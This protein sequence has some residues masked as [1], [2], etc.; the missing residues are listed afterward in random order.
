METAGVPVAAPAR[1]DR[2]G[3]WPDLDLPNVLWFFGAVIAAAASVAIIDKIPESHR[4][5]WEL[6]GSLGFLAAYAL[7]ARLLIRNGWRIPGGLMAADAAVMVPAAG[8]GFTRL[9]DVYPKDS[10]FDPFQ[11]FSGAV[12]GIGCATIVAGLLAYAL[13]R[14][15]ASLFVVVLAV[16]LTAQLLATS[17]DASGDGRSVT[18]IVVGGALVLIGLGLDAVGRR[19]EAFWL[20]L[21]GFA[22]IAGAL[23]YFSLVSEDGERHGWLPMLI[24]GSCVLLLAGPLRRRVWATFGAAGIGGAFIHYVQSKGDWFAYFLLGLAL[25]VFALGLL[26]YA[27]PR[28]EAAPTPAEP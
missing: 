27:S 17:W 6:L 22:G 8:Y 21:G 26:V 13:T 20:H 12:F 10:F 11:D 25:V 2:T 15:T 4:D 3:A 9:I 5:V 19:R 16:Q 14:V 23:A 28:R 24:A 18:A 1:A 7:A